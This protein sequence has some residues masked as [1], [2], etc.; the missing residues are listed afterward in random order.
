MATV[1]C[2]QLPWRRS[3]TCIKKHARAPTLQPLELA[4]SQP[5]T[6]VAISFNAF[7]SCSASKL[8]GSVVREA[9]ICKLV[10]RWL[11]LRQTVLRHRPICRLN[12][13]I[14]QGR[15]PIATSVACR[16]RVRH[17]MYVCMPAGLDNCCGLRDESAATPSTGQLLQRVMACG[18][19]H[20]ACAAVLGTGC[21][22]EEQNCGSMGGSR[23]QI[24]NRDC[25]R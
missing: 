1:K 25:N 12:T 14:L 4:S 3:P 20:R 2:T 5:P 16:W 17:Y 6:D 15:L 13:F 24:D 10:M 18:V 23:P 11:S 9:R 19:L 7:W 21:K 22:N 8:H